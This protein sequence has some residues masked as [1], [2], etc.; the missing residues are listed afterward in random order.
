MEIIA[1]AA[2]T[3][4]SPRRGQWALAAAVAGDP[5]PAATLRASHAA[6]V[7]LNGAA[8]LLA[9]AVTA[10]RDGALDA[11]AKAFEQGDQLL[12]GDRCGL[13]RHLARLL[14][15]PSASGDGWGNPEGW[16]REALTWFEDNGYG[17]LAALARRTL[18]SVGMPVPRRGRGE[19]VVPTV[20]RSQ[21]ITSREM[22]VLLLVE[23]R[24][25]NREIAGKLHLSV[26]T[27]EKHVASLLAKTGV[28]GRRE[29][30]SRP[31]LRQADA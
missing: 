6:S 29:L 9:E 21:G 18:R 8:L 27:V 10:A 16:L 22:D 28:T 14:I 12:S 2:D 23:Q 24:L 30:S 7:S 17:G 13:P 25:S 4:P 20:L 5:E 1:G 15:A 19:S 11:A 31:D 3:I 26:R